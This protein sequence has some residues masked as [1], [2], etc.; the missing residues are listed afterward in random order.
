[1]HRLVAPA[2]AAIPPLPRLAGAKAVAAV[3]KIQPGGA[4]LRPEKA[5]AAS[6]VETLRMMG[7]AATGSRRATLV[8]AELIL[9]VTQAI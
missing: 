4:A 6:G 3:A 1:M 8:V 5:L 9:L 2:P 7:L